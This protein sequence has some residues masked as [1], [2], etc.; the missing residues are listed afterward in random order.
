MMARVMKGDCREVKI[1]NRKSRK[2]RRRLRQ[3]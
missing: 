1:M 3:R 2:S